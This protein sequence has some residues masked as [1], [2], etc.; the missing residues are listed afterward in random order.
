M[1][2]R[3]DKQQKG[4]LRSIDW[5]T[6]ILYL[7]LLSF[8]WVSVCG[9]SYSYG[10]TDIFSLDTRSGMQIIW[11]GTS[12]VLG[13]VLLMLDDRYYDMFAYLIFG[14]MLLLL[15]GTIFNPHSII[16]KYYIHGS[17]FSL[18]QMFNFIF[19]YFLNE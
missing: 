4:V 13:F 12:I 5:W 6:I 11:I 10:D 2:Q 9:A 14:G 1:V 16:C 8:G 7:A 18:C 3:V 19:Q 15:F 17:Y